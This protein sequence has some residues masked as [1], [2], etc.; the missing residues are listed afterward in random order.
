MAPHYSHIISF[1]IGMVNLAMCVT[2]VDHTLGCPQSLGSPGS[3]KYA[4]IIEW[5][6]IN[7]GSKNAEECS[8]RIVSKLKSIFAVGYI[9]DNKNIWVI[10]ERQSHRSYQCLC[11]SHTIFGFFLSKYHNINVNFVSGA[12]KPLKSKGQKRKTESIRETKKWLET[13]ENSDWKSWFAQHKKKDDLA[14]AFMQSIGYMSKVVY[15]PPEPEKPE[16]AI[17]ISDDSDDSEDSDSWGSA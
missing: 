3:N 5:K 8:R 12:A 4:T 17:T 10:I 15:Y 16:S 11:I 14:D 9:P 2:R 1:D 7:L 6:L 13:P